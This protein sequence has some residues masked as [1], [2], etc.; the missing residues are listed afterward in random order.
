MRQPHPFD[1]SSRLLVATAFQTGLI[2]CRQPSRR[3]FDLPVGKLTPVLDDRHAAAGRISAFS[4]VAALCRCSRTRQPLR[5]QRARL[6]PKRQ[7]TRHFLK[8][9]YTSVDR[10]WRSFQF[11]SNQAHLDL[12][13]DELSQLCLFRLCP[14]AASRLWTCHSEKPQMKVLIQSQQAR[15]RKGLGLAQLARRAE[16]GRHAAETGGSLK[17]RSGGKGA[18]RCRC[19]CSSWS[20]RARSRLTTRSAESL[21]NPNRPRT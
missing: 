4:A 20:S 6:L 11:L 13:S 7:F 12:G 21:L 1:G 10:P 2:R 19:T 16:I 14:G 17:R 3:E 15:L 9:V 8:R 5:R 18:T